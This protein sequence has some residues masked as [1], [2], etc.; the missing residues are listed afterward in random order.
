LCI[1]WGAVGRSGFHQMR[2]KVE[3]AR[4]AMQNMHSRAYN[5]EQIKQGLHF[6]TCTAR[7]TLQNP[8]S[9]ACTAD[10]ALTKVY[11]RTCTTSLH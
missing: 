1:V 9:K 10:H 4:P 11:F 7:P 3:T 2:G 5:A 8:C 6:R